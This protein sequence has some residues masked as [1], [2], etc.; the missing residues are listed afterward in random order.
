M[1]NLGS[2]L[3]R[4][5]PCGPP[6]RGALCVWQFVAMRGE[7]GCRVVP[8]HRDVSRHRQPFLIIPFSYFIFPFSF[9][10]LSAWFGAVMGKSEGLSVKGNACKLPAP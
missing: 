7:A 9:F 4:F 1:S 6:Q 10:I 8:I 5:T 2:L 3:Q